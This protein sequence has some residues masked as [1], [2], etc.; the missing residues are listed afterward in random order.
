MNYYRFANMNWKQRTFATL[1]W[2]TLSPFMIYSLFVQ[3]VVYNFAVFLYNFD[4][5]IQNW[6]VKPYDVILKY[7]R[8]EK[9]N[10]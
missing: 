6:L 9:G 3:L 5:K 7:L 2:I 10:D 8:S 4:I 1:Y